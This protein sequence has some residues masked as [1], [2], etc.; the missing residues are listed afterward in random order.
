MSVAPGYWVER[1]FPEVLYHYTDVAGLLGIVNRAALWATHARFL[2][3]A[4]EIVHGVATVKDA[5][6]RSGAENGGH[7]EARYFA[8]RISD[9]EKTAL[10]GGHRDHD[11][12][13]G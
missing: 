12:N 9:I 8:H 3:D 6:K 2:N 5:L 7:L 13:T 10:V 4:T 1:P 11:G